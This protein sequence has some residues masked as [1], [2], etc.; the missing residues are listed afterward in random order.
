LKNSAKARRIIAYLVAV[1]MFIGVLQNIDY[2]TIAAQT[3]TFETEIAVFPESYKPYLRAL[4]TKY[5]EWKFVAYNT[6]ID[7]STAVYNEASNNKSLIEKNY[8]SLLLSRATND[9]NAATGAY[10]LK[11]GKTWVSASENTVAYFMD[12]RNF[13]TEN[14]V[15]MF[16]QLSYDSTVH[17]QQGV[18]AILKDSFMHNTNIGYLDAAGKY[19]STKEKYSAK[20]VEAAIQS[21][22]SPYFLA[23]KSILEVG[24]RANSSYEGMGSGSSIN[25]QYSGYKGIYNFYNIGA[26]DGANAVANGL[27]WASSG[28]S[29]NRP[30]NTPGKSIIGGAIYIGEKFIKAGQ[31]T[32]Y[33]QRF[34]VKSDCDYAL[35]THQYMTS[36]YGNAAESMSTSSA[37]ISQGIMGAEK[38]FIIPVYDNM[39][40]KTTT[41]TSYGEETKTGLTNSNVNMRVGSSTK[42]D[43]ILTVSQGTE[44][45]ILDTVM[46]QEPYGLL[47]LNNPYWYKVNVKI[48]DTTYTGYLSATYVDVNSELNVIKGVTESVVA[49][50]SVAETVYY[51]TDNP[52]IATV[53]ANGNI[54]GISSGT[55]TIRAYTQC[56]DMVPLGITV[57]EDGVNITEYK[58]NIN[59]GTTKKLTA[60]VYPTTATDKTVTWTSSNTKVATVSSDGTV[61]AI[62]KGKATITAKATIG[63]VTDKCKVTVIRPVKGITLNRK[64]KK[65]IVGQ[66]YTLVPTITPADASI[67][68]VT[69]TSSNDKLATV[70]DGVVTGVSPGVVTITATTNNEGKVATCTFKIKP[71][72]TKITKIKSKSHDSLTV[73]WEPVQDITGYKVFRKGSK[74]K[75]KLIALV[76]ASKTKYKDK[77]L[78]TG[79][80]FTYKITTY[81]IVDGQERISIRS[82][83]FKATVKPPK[84]KITVAKKKKKSVKI[85]IKEVAGANGYYIYRK[86]AGTTGYKEIGKTS[87][88]T[89]VDKGLKKGTTYY[90][91]VKAYRKVGKKEVLSNYS[92][93]VS[94]KRAK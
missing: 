29:Y 37:Y 12:P 33:F 5:P 69:W 38:T 4:H 76:D 86:V 15:V 31:D 19:Y 84:P 3:D 7:F 78:K 71:K 75:Y 48:G 63:G 24:A 58:V 28:S 67:Q 10:I 46:T 30:W 65:V 64:K 59:E 60:T 11:D 89:F 92:T 34:N 25:G 55:T 40:E 23:S 87:K 47:W 57:V 54:K 83:A 8:N 42:T 43:I 91:K 27:S 13:L 45:E 14:Y 62:S 72:S 74:G 41:I 90:Y 88:L 6:G 52:A 61:T 44:V 82:E 22:V 21:G 2:V 70:K 35:Y 56:G 16:E 39:P 93:R 53:D 80:V 66:S 20:F 85:T 81:K 26:S 73:I 9:Y 51:E 36:I 94:Y 17:T 32:T 79:K 1:A 77:G 68:T 18:E 50:T 49:T